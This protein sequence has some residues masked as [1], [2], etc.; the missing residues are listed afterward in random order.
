METIFLSSVDRS[1]SLTDYCIDF[2]HNSDKSI[3]KQGIDKRFNENLKTMLKKLVEEVMAKQIS[4]KANLKGIGKHFTEI[5]LMDSTEF[6][7]SK[8][9]AG[10]FPGYGPGREAIAQI[11]FEYDLLSGKVNQMRVGSALDSDVTEGWKEIDKVPKQ[12]LLIRDLGYFYPKT[13]HDLQEREIYYVSRAKSQWNIYLKDEKGYQR[14][15]TIQIIEKLKAQ[16]QKYLDLEVFVGEKFKAPMRLIANLLTEEQ[17]QK[18]IKKKTDRSGRLGKDALEGCG[19]NLFVSNIEKDKC[20]A[21]TIYELYRLRWQI[22][23]RGRPRDFQNLEKHP[24]SA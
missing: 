15:T 24:E 23:P 22:E 16:K 18:R 11:Q 10:K 2:Q 8:N 20:D 21:A 12:S 13:F 5:R 19:L 9:V 7:L 4:R 1:P 17:A 6:K 3:S 14:L